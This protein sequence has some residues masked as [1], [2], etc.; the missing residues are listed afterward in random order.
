MAQ[1]AEGAGPVFLRNPNNP[2]AAVLGHRAV[3]DFVA[4]VTK[5]SPKTL[6]LADEAYHDKVD[7]PGYATA[8]PLALTNPQ[9]VVSRTFSKAFGRAWFEKA[10]CWGE[11]G[12]PR[13]SGVDASGRLAP[14]TWMTAPQGAA[15]PRFPTRSRTSEARSPKP[16]CTS[17]HALLC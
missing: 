7:D 16:L 15:P 14:A 13:A 5:A 12:G 1:A 3:A 2:I 6:V 8:I 4:Q 17:R 9:V 11:G 10:G